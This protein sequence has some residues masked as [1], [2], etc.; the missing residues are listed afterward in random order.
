[1]LRA[2]GRRLPQLCPQSVSISEHVALYSSG[3]AGRVDYAI[4]KDS[5]SHGLAEDVLRMV[6]DTRPSP[7]A[8]GAGSVLLKMLAAPINPADISCI[9]GRYPLHPESEEAACRPGFEGV[10]VVEAVGPGVTRFKPGDLAV[11]IEAFQG[12]WRTFAT[13]NENHWYRVPGDL[14]LSTAATLS[15]NPPTAL[16]MLEEFVELKAGDAIV[17]TGGN[18]STGKYI[19]QLAKN[20]GIRCISVIRDRP[21]AERRAIEKELVEFGADMVVTADELGDA[22]RSWPHGRPKLGM[23]C[24][25]GQTTLEV[26]KVLAKDAV[27]VVYGGMSR[28]PLQ[29][30]PGSLI[31]DNITVKGFWLTGGY[32]QM[33]HGSRAKELL[34][35]RVIALFRQKILKPAQVECMPL[36]EWR[37]GL[38]LY[39]SS[40][41]TKVLLTNYEED[42]CL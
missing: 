20:R 35:D 8:L 6:P 27:L 28:Q 11:P 37:R 29:I 40:H 31:F 15:I 26:A 41:T 18:S 24:V 12:T 38:E 1:M 13:V 21:A 19:L 7:D 32:A 25:G 36:A 22:V 9:E 34:V 23:D 5:K 33:K 3:G 14:S 39:R 2:A 30:P 10:G 17:H 16:R 4:V 42:V